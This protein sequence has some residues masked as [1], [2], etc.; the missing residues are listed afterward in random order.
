MIVKFSSG[1]AL[2]AMAISMPAFAQ[3][4]AATTAMVADDVIV[5]TARKRAEDIQTVPIT[6]DSF[7]AETLREK[8]IQ[9]LAD[10]SNSTPSLAI[11]TIGGGALVTI[12]IRGQAPANTNNDLN[13]EANVGVFI[14]GIY[15]TSRNT[16]DLISVLDIGQIDIVKGPQSALYGRSTF[17][18]ALGI[19]T[20]APSRELSG[21]IEGTIGT[22][23]DYRA[24]G[25]ISGPIIKDKLFGRL[26]A[27]YVGFGG[28]AENI[29][30][31]NTGGYKKY[32]VSG[33]LEA[34]LSDRFTARLNAFAVHSE[35]EV[36]G[37]RLVK[38][39]ENNCGLVEPVSGFSTL[40]CGPLIA[41][42]INDV[43]PNIPDTTFSTQQVSLDLTYESDNFTLVSVTG[44]TQAKNRTYN[45]YDGS[46]EGLLMGVSTCPPGPAFLC[47]GNLP[48]S[49]LVNVNVH[50]SAR[51][52]VATFNQ[53]LRIQSPDANKFQWMLGAFYF[54]SRI[55]DAFNPGVDTHLLNGA[56]LA[57]GE[58]LRQNF[59]G[60]PANQG[61]IDFTTLTFGPTGVNEYVATGLTNA[62]TKT[63]SVFGS[64]GYDFGQVRVSAEGRYNID[65]K[66]TNP[67]GAGGATVSIEVEN[68]GQGFPI[69]GPRL[70]RKFK[71]FTPRFSI[72]YR[73]T[74]DLFLYA[75][76]AKGV[77]SGGFNAQNPGNPILPEEVPYEEEKN[78]TYEI[79]IKSSWLDR[80]VM[81]NLA[82]YRVDWSDMQIGVFSENPGASV[83]PTVIVANASRYRVEGVEGNI[84]LR[85]SDR[86][87][88]G[89]A[90]N[91]S[92]PRFLPGSFDTTRRG[93]CINAAGVGVAPC[94]ATSTIIAGN[95][96]PIVV[97][98]LTGKRTSRSVK[99]SWNLHATANIPLG[100]DWQATGR[101]D[102]NHTG[103]SFAD[104]INSS[105]ISAFTLTNLRFG[106]DNGKYSIAVFATNVF[107]KIYVQNAIVQPRANLPF[108]IRVPEAVQAERRRV[109]VTA[110]ARF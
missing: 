69:A 105:E 47:F 30:G 99:T 3:K 83:I 93:Q 56:T 110:S 73:P 75:S 92:N 39:Q 66:N 46:S 70:E 5:V 97:P 8:S 82:A 63:T 12:Y 67:F 86:F 6:I 35:T 52:N 19:F 44:L 25:S 28:T 18:G 98:D 23:D 107:D 13:T 90:F 59:P 4:T 94:L 53:E 106:L 50:T 81:V 21:R 32:A 27:G 14:D 87:G 71:S 43:S 76:A 104:L 62:Q 95:G 24:R 91:V 100:N 109:G 57:P 1:A 78:W 45:E 20:N 74:D 40:R 72:D 31:E 68:P 84:E 55:R 37:I 64:L 16:V 88:I 101:V 102:V 49:R 79:G 9:T 34:L 29:V 10:L 22:N 85:P 26:S 15:Q 41:E 61:P 36:G 11:N 48:F 7:T 2:L 65:D 80:R 51:E 42:R 103:N 54:N 96:T 108:A 58:T 77:R 60:L 33:S 17:A 38:P 89:G